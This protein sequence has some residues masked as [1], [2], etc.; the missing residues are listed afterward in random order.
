MEDLVHHTIAHQ[1]DT[2]GRK[3]SSLVLGS[4]VVCHVGRGQGRWMNLKSA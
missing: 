1:A 3:G 4:G 2:N